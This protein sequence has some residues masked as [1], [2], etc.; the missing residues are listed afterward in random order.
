MDGLSR[1]TGFARLVQSIRAGGTAAEAAF[2]RVFSEYASSLRVYL[3]ARSHDA[4][5]SDDLLQECFIRFLR[6]VRKG[7]EIRHPAYLWKIADSVLVD[8]HRRESAAVR[9]TE[10][11]T[12]IEE[13]VDYPDS[14]PAPDADGRELFDCIER[15]LVDYSSTHPSHANVVE[16]AIVEQWTIDEMSEYLERTCAATRQ[17]LY[18]VRKRLRNFVRERCGAL[19]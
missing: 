8:H 14:A 7:V 19:M 2:S 4:A 18:E 17:Y 15:A 6:S 16:L 10:R 12:P 13:G 11:T 1:D 3:L 9:S 5:A